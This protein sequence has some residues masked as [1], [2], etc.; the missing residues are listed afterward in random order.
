MENARRSR[1]VLAV[2]ALLFMG[3]VELA[4]LRQAAAAGPW[5]I[6]EDSL[7]LAAT[8]VRLPTSVGGWL[9]VLDCDG[10]RPGRYRIAE[11]AQF[12]L[13]GQAVTF[14]EMLAAADSGRYGSMFIDLRRASGEVSRIRV[15]P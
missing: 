7:E 6:E 8:Y 2:S 14:N 9:T 15:Y 5:V 1:T 13:R 10:C 3:V 12:E 11:D 4:G